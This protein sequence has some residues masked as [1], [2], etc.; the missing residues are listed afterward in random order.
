MIT[1]KK[2]DETPYE[3]VSHKKKYYKDKEDKVKYYKQRAN[4]ETL[5]LDERGEAEDIYWRLKNGEGVETDEDIEETFSYRAEICNVEASDLI[6]Q[7][8][9]FDSIPPI[10]DV[11]L[12]YLAYDGKK[13][14]EPYYIFKGI[15][16]N[17]SNCMRIDYIVRNP[18]A[19]NDTT[20]YLGDKL[21]KLLRKKDAIKEFYVRHPADWAKKLIQ[22]LD[23][24]IL[25]AK[26]GL[27]SQLIYNKY[28]VSV[29]NK[30]QIDSM[31]SV[32]YK[33]VKMDPLK[34]VIFTP[35][36]EVVQWPNRLDAVSFGLNST[37]SLFFS[38][39][40]KYK[41]SWNCI[42]LN[43]TVRVIGLLDIPKDLSVRLS[44]W[45][46]T[47]ILTAYRQFDINVKQKKML[48]FLLMH[49]VVYFGY[50]CFDSNDV[51]IF[52]KTFNTCL[53]KIPCVF[54]PPERVDF[55]TNKIWG[56]FPPF[57]IMDR[58]NIGEGV[59]GCYTGMF[60][61]VREDYKVLR[62]RDIISEG[63]EITMGK[64]GLRI[65]QIQVDGFTNKLEKF[66]LI[67]T[68]DILRF[69]RSF[70]YSK[71]RLFGDCEHIGP[72]CIEMLI[73]DILI[74]RG[75]NQDVAI[76]YAAAIRYKVYFVMRDIYVKRP[77]SFV[78]F[79]AT[80]QSLCKFA[81]H[82]SLTGFRFDYCLDCKLYFA[83]REGADRI[84]FEGGGLAVIFLAWLSEALKS[85]ES[86]TQTDIVLKYI[87]QFSETIRTI[88][89][90]Y[91]DGQSVSFEFPSKGELFKEYTNDERMLYEAPFE[92]Q[93]LKLTE[94]EVKN[95][96]EKGIRM[97]SK[98]DEAGRR[99]GNFLQL[100]TVLSPGLWIAM[101]L[102]LRAFADEF[103]T[104]AYIAY[105]NKEDYE[106]KRF[107]VFKQFM[108]G[109]FKG[110]TPPLTVY[111]QPN[112]ILDLS[113]FQQGEIGLGA[114][115]KSCIQLI[116]D[117]KKAYIDEHYFSIFEKA[118]G[119]WFKS[120]NCTI[121][122]IPLGI[123]K[124]EDDTILNFDLEQ[125]RKLVAIADARKDSS[126]SKKKNKKVKVEKTEEQVKQEL[127]ALFRR[128]DSSHMGQ[129][130]GKHGGQK[131]K[132]KK[133]FQPNQSTDVGVVV[134][135]FIDKAT[136]TLKGEKLVQQFQVNQEKIKSTEQQKRD[137][138][139]D[140]VLNKMKEKKKML[141]KSKF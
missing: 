99:A 69:E 130:K 105:F 56:L 132:S 30:F 138:I 34:N 79:N 114:E 75:S 13:V 66:I 111:L 123:I 80:R 42:R 81:T 141:Q 23:D 78:R 48:G 8:R 38:T 103:F 135:Q 87:N 92:V 6:K 57:E 95:C 35:G 131:R 39:W 7:C 119:D 90:Y 108:H 128:H 70:I 24:Y 124:N 61:I 96:Y 47:K 62:L 65:G 106:E 28:Q 41:Y 76:E 104:C 133:T 46:I 4:N 18:L 107:C 67:H 16:I 1:N 129:I 29:D 63:T 10:P 88:K 83:I 2:E 5:S 109:I 43:P 84:S 93:Q 91:F 15:A 122:E 72:K 33:E 12:A 126:S 102:N 52:G 89:I 21:E 120:N 125:Q 64:V 11:M 22:D 113:P 45:L 20:K 100:R 26:N 101:N 32:K 117:I 27:D 116:I 53:R 17:V 36:P 51:S 25:E 71:G 60:T 74:C 50:F 40:A 94:Q 136:E 59:W 112:V 98:K 54:M 82:R 110:L 73:N 86:Y 58:F 127:K 77:N 68:L 55:V 134:R 3:Q 31:L 140:E 115:K 85:F 137:R 44:E 139:N 121:T 97:T 118:Y 49:G 19:T 9:L 37:I 14:S